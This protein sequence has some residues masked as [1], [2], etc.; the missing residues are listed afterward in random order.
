MSLDWHLCLSCGQPGGQDGYGYCFDCSWEMA[1]V[2]AG[3]DPTMPSIADIAFDLEAA[4]DALRDLGYNSIAG[5]IKPVIK[6]IDKE[7][8]HSDEVIGR[9]NK[10]KTSGAPV[11]PAKPVVELTRAAAR[12]KEEA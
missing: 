9:H 2:M 12:R 5:M 8:W 1:D 4:R 10:A 7:L 6:A 11:K 3:D